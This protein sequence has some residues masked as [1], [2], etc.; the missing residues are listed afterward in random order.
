[1]ERSSQ[2]NPYA[3]P[4]VPA[5]RSLFEESLN[6][7]KAS[8]KQVDDTEKDETADKSAEYEL[9]DSLS[10]DDYAES[11]GKLNISAE[12]SSKGED[13][14]STFDPSQYEE[15]DVDHHFAVVESLTKMFPDVSADFIV[16]ALKAH[17]F[18]A[19]VSLLHVYD[20]TYRSLSR[21]LHNPFGVADSL[22]A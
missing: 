19:V 1:M 13:T 7:R 3:T 6:V 15:N 21:D 18:H 2:L 20:F 10:L 8:E 5:S 4:F 14:S 11:L 17:E 22:D 12:S 9:P 16:E